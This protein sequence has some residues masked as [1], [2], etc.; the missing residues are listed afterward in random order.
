MM[1]FT[2]G[3]QIATGLIAG[4]TAMVLTACVD[5]TQLAE[6]GI[7]GTGMSIGPITA[8]G[9]VYVNG[10]R[11]ETNETV[12]SDDGISS[13]SDLEEGMI[14]IIEGQWRADG[15]GEATEVRYDDTLRGSVQQAEWDPLTKTGTITLLEQNITLNSQTVFRGKSADSITVGDYVRISGW[16]INE[17]GFR[18][19][20]VRTGSVGDFGGANEAE[21]EGVVS[22]LSATNGIGTFLLGGLTVRFDGATEFDDMGVTDLANGLVVDVEGSLEH[23]GVLY[24]TE[25]E[26]VASRYRQ[27]EG[28]DIEFS[29]AI[30]G[31]YDSVNRQFQ[32]LGL[33]VQVTADTEFD[34]ELVES[35]LKEGLL[36]KV[37]GEFNSDGIVVAEEI[38]LRETDSEL[39]GKISTIND[40]NQ[41][42]EVGGVRVVVSSNTII[43]DDEDDLRLTFKDLNVGDYLEIDGIDGRDSGG[44]ILLATKIERDDDDDDGYELTGRINEVNSQQNYIVVLGVKI[45]VDGAKLGDFESL[46]DLNIGDLVSV[47]YELINNRYVADDIEFEEEDD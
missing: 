33:I 2:F 8:F 31:P 7:R 32:M 16:R 18:A 35:D 14:L 17:G 36:I 34:D 3:K 47:E 40:A 29:G 28:G 22:A 26:P 4:A 6:G 37:E 23:D 27:T 10:T 41:S 30:T 25:I 5:A 12:I 13:E 38:E 45:E 24:A 39:E 11:F 21:V 1:I 43:V 46:S 42:L 15:E 19:S 9:S 20:Y 44:P